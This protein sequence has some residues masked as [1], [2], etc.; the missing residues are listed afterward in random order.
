[1]L[2]KFTCNDKKT[3]FFRT[4]DNNHCVLKT[5]QHNFLNCQLPHG[6]TL[7]PW[8]IGFNILSAGAQYT[9]FH[10]DWEDPCDAFI[11]LH[12][13]GKRFWVFLNPCKMAANLERFS[14]NPSSSIHQLDYFK[15]YAVQGWQLPGDTVYLPF[16]Q[17]H[18]VLTI[19]RPDQ[20]TCLLSVSTF[21]SPKDQKMAWPGIAQERL[22]KQREIQRSQG[23]ITT[24]LVSYFIYLIFSSIIYYFVVTFVSC[25]SP[26]CHF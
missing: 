12:G 18:C 9:N 6:F 1:M 21:I 7:S 22:Q 4:K 2:S 8:S 14:E 11:T 16:G 25:I 26:Q 15:D 17:Y 5:T 20:W 13:T 23:V 3:G 19:A 10:C 24:L